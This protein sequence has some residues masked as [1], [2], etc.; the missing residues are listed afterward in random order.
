MWY[1]PLLR[2]NLIPDSVIR[3]GIRQLLK[4]RITQQ[5]GQDQHRVQ[6]LK[7]SFIDVMKSS[8]LAIHTAEANQQHYE[9]PTEFYQKVLGHRLKYSS[10]LWTPEVKDLDASELAMLDMTIN[11][12]GVENGM[13]ILEL[14]CGWGS[15]SLYMAARFPRCRVTAVSNSRTQKEYI[16]TQAA[17][18]GIT[19]LTVITADM[20]GFQAPERYDR[21]V[22][23]EMFEHMRNY[24]LLLRRVSS[25]LKSDGRLFVHIF[26]HDRF[27]YPFE[28]EEANDWMARYFFTGGLMP[29]FDIFSYFSK[30]LQVEQ[31]WAVNGRHYEKTLN[32]WLAGMDEKKSE[33]K[34]LFIQTYGK[35]WKTWWV[36]WRIFFMACAELFGYHDGKEWYVGHYLLKRTGDR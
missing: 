17:R 1:L 9:V 12:A 35:E 25:W 18:E 24:D 16:D 20:N 3:R 23:V 14:G 36:Y 7:S 32:A 6:E 5:G 10:C 26:V 11:R 28:T 4:D 22:S 19:N 21:I 33:L 31:Q 2:N 30:D 29:S 13:D 8:P 15:L 34:P 27:A